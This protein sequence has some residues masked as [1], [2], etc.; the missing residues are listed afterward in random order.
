MSTA[1]KYAIGFFVV[2]LVFV[3][4]LSVIGFGYARACGKASEK[5]DTPAPALN[6][7]K[8]HCGNGGHGYVHSHSWFYWNNTTTSYGQSNRAGSVGGANPLAGGPGYGK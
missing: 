8:H 6:T 4:Y 5:Q 1:E 3:T 2:L 7:E